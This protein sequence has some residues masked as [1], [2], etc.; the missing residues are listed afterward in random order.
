MDLSFLI[1]FFHSFM[2][3]VGDFLEGSFSFFFERELE[4]TKT[5]VSECL[6]EKQK[7]M[8]IFMKKN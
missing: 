6:R 1:L 7:G 8:E 2:L 3:E 5:I 4:N